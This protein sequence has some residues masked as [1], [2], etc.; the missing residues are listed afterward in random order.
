MQISQGRLA[1]LALMNCQ[2]QRQ[3]S[4]TGQTTAL[5]K[6][7]CW[8]MRQSKGL[9]RKGKKRNL[10]LVLNWQNP[11]RNSA[12]L[13]LHLGNKQPLF[14]LF[15]SN[16]LAHLPCSRLCSKSCN[17]LDT[18]SYFR[19]PSII[20]RLDKQVNID[21]NSATSSPTRALP[22][23]ARHTFVTASLKSRGKH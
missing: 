17:R 1:N 15:H 23:E 5:K 2:V 20:Q 3:K 14:K 10:S 13:W 9:D 18:V 4:R 19:R 11:P 21:S 22:L 12:Q 16:N 7:A 8:I 6:K